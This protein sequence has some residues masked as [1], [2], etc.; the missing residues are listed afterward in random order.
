M[1]KLSYQDWRALPLAERRLLMRAA[2]G[3]TRIAP[4]VVDGFDLSHLRGVLD[5][6]EAQA[7]WM[8]GKWTEGEDDPCE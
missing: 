5:S 3:D 7:A 1:R 6:H 8:P 2:Y 4:E